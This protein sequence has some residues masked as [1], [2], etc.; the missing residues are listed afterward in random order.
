MHTA[1]P[2]PILIQP[3]YALPFHKRKIQ[4]FHSL[5]YF[6]A[7]GPDRHLY[8]LATNVTPGVFA[9]RRSMAEAV[10]GTDDPEEIQKHFDTWEHFLESARTLKDF[11]GGG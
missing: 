10:F 8:A 5:A 3:M 6:A 2:V 1:Q 7:T 11:T 9:Y 4:P